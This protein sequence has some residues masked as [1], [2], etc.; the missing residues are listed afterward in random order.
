MDFCHR[1]VLLA[2]LVLASVQPGARALAAEQS[3]AEADDVFLD[4]D[5]GDA[6]AAEN[7]QS[8]SSDEIRFTFQ[9]E[10]S[11]KFNEPSAV[12]T[13]RSSL[14]V[15]W[16]KLLGDGFYAKV[17]FKYNVFWNQDMRLAE[18]ESVGDE[19]RFRNTYLQKNWGQTSL[20]IGEQIVVWGET[21]TAVVTDIFSPRNQA[22]FIFTSLEESRLSQLM[23]KLDY[24]NEAG[25]FSLLIN[26]DVEVDTNPFSEILPPGMVLE[27][28]SL[29]F[30]SE[31]GVRW[32]KVI[33]RGDYSLFFADIN[34]N[35]VV[36]RLKRE[37]NNQLVVQDEYSRYQMLGAATNYT[38]G[39]A[40]LQV[41]MAYN[42][43]RGFQ[44][45]GPYSAGNN[46]VF[47]S[48][49]LQASVA[50]NYTQNATRNWILGLGHQHVFEESPYQSEDFRNM[51]D[52][53]F[54]V[55]E[56]FRY[57][58]LT[59]SYTLQYQFAQDSAI[60]N[61]SSKYQISDNLTLQMDGFL[62]DGLGADRAYKNR[63]LLLRA[64]YS[65]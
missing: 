44:T 35:A 57:E 32:R 55:G 33:G 3:E 12:Q 52:L 26:P 56:K 6:A 14:Q 21:E 31:L 5:L 22:D 48:D 60:H 25:Q 61:L 54:S 9:Q 24:F 41:E 30:D 38:S 10:G 59:L 27:K 18:D 7:G 34:D 58:T 45:S 19:F 16:D 17:D 47:N 43:D 62:L 28:N 64:S 51:T 42:R 13:N 46:G 29:D 20:A 65:F 49:Q 50:L 2:V 36:Y 40:A 53:V 11:Y 23:V 1:H 37:E 39:N 63:S 15:Q 4:M 8:T